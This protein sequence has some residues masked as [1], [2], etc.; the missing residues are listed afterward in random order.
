MK[1]LFV[2]LVGC[3]TLWFIGALVLLVVGKGASMKEWAAITFGIPAV[4]WAVY[5]SMALACRIVD[6]PRDK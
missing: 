5:G 6:K 4:F 1:I 3:T 2:L